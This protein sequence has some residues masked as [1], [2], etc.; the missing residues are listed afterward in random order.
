MFYLLPHSF[1][2]SSAINCDRD[3]VCMLETCM[4]SMILSIKGFGPV[5]NPNLSPELKIF[6]KL[7]NLKTLPSVSI[8]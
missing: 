3:V 8:E 4:C 7:S 2:K 1:N 6:E 5:T